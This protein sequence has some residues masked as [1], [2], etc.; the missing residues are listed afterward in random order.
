MSFFQPTLKVNDREFQ[1]ALEQLADLKKDKPGGF[2]KFI[3][4]IGKR[5][6]T[7][8]VHFTPP[9]SQATSQESYNAQRKIGEN[10][11][12]RDVGR[13]FQD[14]GKLRIFENPNKEVQKLL[15]SK[16]PATIQAFLKAAGIRGNVALNAEPFL[17]Q[18]RRDSRGRVPK[19]FKGNNFVIN[20]KS[21][22]SYAKSKVKHVGTAKS[23]WVKAAQGCGAKLPM[24]ITK[25]AGAQAGTFKDRSQALAPYIE[26]SNDVPFIQRT[27]AD[28][29]IMDRATKNVARNMEK[30]SQH[31]IE[32]RGK[33][34]GF[35]THV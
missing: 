29:K 5:F 21:A 27:G 9:F 20:W 11:T 2:P 26:F 30:E 15:K 35:K 12:F 13:V 32:A 14:L 23:G 7:D 31:I 33:K 18:N 10:A 25:Q 19:T 6:V 4:S 3:K 8:V 1:R 24:W 22:Q 28:L 17:H 34:A 16:N